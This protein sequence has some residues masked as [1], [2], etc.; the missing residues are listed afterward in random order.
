MRTKHALFAILTT[1]LVIVTQ[2]LPAE[3]GRGCRRAQ[4]RAARCQCYI[5]CERGNPCQRTV[6]EAGWIHNY[7]CPR[8]LFATFV[9][10]DVTYEQWD[11]SNC[12]YAIGFCYQ[13]DN[14]FV[15]R[16]FPAGVQAVPDCTVSGICAKSCDKCVCLVSGKYKKDS[17]NSLEPT[18]EPGLPVPGIEIAAVTS[19]NPIAGF[20]FQANS[21]RNVKFNN[22]TRDVFARIYVI[23]A[24][25]ATPTRAYRVGIEIAQPSAFEDWTMNSP[26]VK[27]RESHLFLVQ[28]PNTNFEYTILISQ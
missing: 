25:V 7:Q 2:A 6:L 10:N 22:G 23:E 20:R 19:I 4:R 24:D 15:V 5:P 18:D 11:C 27:R 14:N 26:V 3:A 16:N 8:T 13:V 1:V 12:Q 21:Q 17:E 9:V 28:E